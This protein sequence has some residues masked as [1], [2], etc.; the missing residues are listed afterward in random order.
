[1]GAVWE[2]SGD[3]GSPAT[4]IRDGCG[5]LCQCWELNPRSLQK[6]PVLLITEPHL[7]PFKWGFCGIWTLWQAS[8]LRIK[9]S[10]TFSL[11]HFPPPLSPAPVA[12]ANPKLCWDHSNVT[13]HCFITVTF[14]FIY[15]FSS[16]FFFALKSCGRF[17]CFSPP[18]PILP[19]L[20]PFFPLSFLF[21][22]FFWHFLLCSLGWSETCYVGQSGL[23]HTKIYFG[24]A[25]WVLGW[26]LYTTLPGLWWIFFFLVLPSSGFIAPMF[27]IYLYDCFCLQY[28][29]C[30]VNFAMGMI[31]IHLHLEVSLNSC[32][33]LSAVITGIPHTLRS[34]LV[35]C[36]HI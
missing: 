15:I 7:Q 17:F 8:D 5:L 20:P 31:R 10:F 34:S 29:Y 36:T 25:S 6:Q 27:L 16:S 26:T 2:G 33:I 24:S 19:S 3:I 32:V 4:G 35:V 23:E 9:R 11:P 1:M 22:S 14:F 13:S 18:P 28:I 12:Q 30:N 21:F